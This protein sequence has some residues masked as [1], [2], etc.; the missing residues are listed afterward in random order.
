MQTTN[1]IR[2]GQDVAPL[3]VTADL[4]GTAVL[5]V[6]DEVIVGLQD[7]VIEFD[8]RKALFHT[9]FIGLGR[10]HAIDAEV[11]ADVAQE[12]E[13]VEGGQ[14]IGVVDHNRLVASIGDEAANLRLDRLAIFAD[15]VDG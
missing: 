11:T 1:E 9:H 12:G 2:A 5:A 14:P 15:G 10:Q 6:E 8:E 4:Q 7:L 13:V 3:I